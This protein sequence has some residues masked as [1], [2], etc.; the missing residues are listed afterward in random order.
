MEHLHPQVNSYPT[1]GKQQTDVSYQ[2]NTMSTDRCLS[3]VR[4]SLGHETSVTSVSRTTGGSVLND[5]AVTSGARCHAVVTNSSKT[6]DHTRDNPFR[7]TGMST[8]VYVSTEK[9]LRVCQFHF[10]RKRLPHSSADEP[11][12][13]TFADRLDFR[14]SGHYAPSTGGRTHGNIFSVNLHDAAVFAC[15]RPAPHRTARV[16]GAKGA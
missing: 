2:V 3:D 13:R 1:T 5:A 16:N 7:T 12:H 8:R 14:P 15:T 11:E 10:R 6:R 9:W 4:R